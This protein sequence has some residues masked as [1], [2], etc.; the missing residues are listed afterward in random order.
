MVQMIS[1]A[2]IKLDDSPKP[3]KMLNNLDSNIDFLD[4]LLKNLDEK[5]EKKDEDF[6]DNQKIIDSIDSKDDKDIEIELKDIK[7]LKL[8]TQNTALNN[9]QE[10]VKEIKNIITSKIQQENIILSK[11]DLKEF[12]KI[13]NIKD[14]IKFSQKKDLNIKQVK[15][16]LPKEIKSEF[17]KEFEKI[18]NLNT[19]DILVKKSKLKQND[20]NNLKPSLQ[21]PKFMDNIS[22]KTPKIMQNNNKKNITDIKLD[23]K[24]VDKN[25]IS[26]ATILQNN[27]NRSVKEEKIIKDT[28]L[29]TLSTKTDKIKENIK[30][31]NILNDDKPIK[32]VTKKTDDMLV[33]INQQAIQ[34][35]KAKSVQ[36]KQTIESFKNDLDEAIKNYKP[37]VSKVDIELNPKN[38]GKVEVTIIQRG[39]TIQ[40]NMNTDHNNIALFQQHQT[41]FRQALANIGFSNIDMS[42][43]SNQ[44][45]ERKQ[46][47]AKKAYEEQEEEFNEIE[48]NANY[49]PNYRYA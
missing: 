7:S 11:Q 37:P 41:E 30:L 38:L 16:T 35:I 21:Q 25:N 5:Q 22:N 39:N 10:I 18:K 44:D 23:N 42:F 26:L 15:F 6:D 33:N 12:K 20:I 4:L 3:V 2:D 9:N 29:T 27:Q 43:N 45:K 48:I 36:A 14:L 40:I 31:E 46:N 24:V 47:Q 17:R 28:N 49:T 19:K 32:K 1:L 34:E 13:D 8:F